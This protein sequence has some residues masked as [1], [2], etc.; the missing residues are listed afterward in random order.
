MP[1]L[2]I[3]ATTIEPEALAQ[4]NLLLA[5][6]AFCDCKVRI[7]PD[8]HAGK[9]C[10][11]GFT[12][13]LGEYVI[14][15][16][17]GVDI[18]CG[19]LT[20]DIGRQALD[21]G[22]LDAL[23]RSRVPH[24]TGVHES[25]IAR[26]DGLREMAC[27]RA[28]TGVERLERSIGTLGGGNHFI[29]VDADEDGRRYLVIHTGSR[30]LGKQVAEHYQSLA[31]KRARDRQVSLPK[32][33]PAG[34]DLVGGR[35]KQLR[36]AKK[37]QKAP[38]EGAIPRDLCHLSGGDRADYLRDMRI[39]QQYAA[40]NRAQ[41]AHLI[42]KNM[43]LSEDGRFET[44]HNYI[45]HESNIVRKGAIRAAKGERV[46]I[47]INMRDGCIIAIGK[48]NDDWNQSAPHGAGRLMSR[49]QAKKTLS[50]DEYRRAMAG[51]HTSSVSEKTLDEAPMAYKPMEEILK[52]ISDTAEVERII[53]PLYNFKA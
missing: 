3:F 18:G 31:V 22:A 1:N 32:Q 20:V 24:G 19:M 4:I 17:V 42:L 49:S 46:L 5:Q 36:S 37:R 34:E 2:K 50:M 48:G 51:I 6:G 25:P 30:N 14:P 44:I 40:L 16:I 28:L 45:D 53:R 10:V 12:A 43:R 41:I 47:P 39:C 52:S 23:I 29:E 21:L 9:G 27:F 13:D 11:I 33:A 26:F 7:M 35:K 8:V 15:N 38:D